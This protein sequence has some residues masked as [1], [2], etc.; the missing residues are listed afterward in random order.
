MKSDLGF[1]FVTSYVRTVSIVSV[2]H[3]IIILGLSMQLY[4]P[5]R[6]FWEI[7]GLSG[8]KWSTRNDDDVLP[9]SVTNY[10]NDRQVS[11]ML[12]SSPLTDY[13]A[14]LISIIIGYSSLIGRVGNLEVYFLTVI[15]TF[16]Y[17][18]VAMIF[19]R[20][21]VT[22]CGFGMRIFLYGGCLG[23]FASLILGKKNTTLAHPRF[24]SDYYTQALNL[25]GAI[26]IWSLLPVLNWSDLWH[27]SSVGKDSY[28][29]HIAS[30]NMWLALCGSA[31][32]CTC[33]CIG[34][35][36]KLSVHTFV[37][38]VFTVLLRL[39]RVGLRTHLFRI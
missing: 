1:G 29:L 23:L 13:I 15:G 5:F 14:C 31:I 30:L 37:F 6:G 28:I 3:V 18:F 38:S 32:G 12:V 7:I 19:W 10:F 20:I 16:L 25:F 27:V 33:G 21:F 24:L 8:T 34:V 35:Y 17:E 9:V 39:F 26:I 11:Q 22:D 4:F 36:K 2:T